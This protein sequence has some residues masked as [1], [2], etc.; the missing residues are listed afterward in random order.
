MTSRLRVAAGLPAI[1]IAVAGCS[2]TVTGATGSTGPTRD[3]SVGATTP[4]GVTT[5][6]EFADADS[7]NPYLIEVDPPD[8][9]VPADG[10]TDLQVT[11]NLGDLVLTVDHGTAPCAAASLVHL[12]GTGFFTGTACHREVD[13]DVVRMLQ[14][15]DPTGTGVGGPTYTSPTEVTG[16]ETYP[17]GTIAMVNSGQGVDGSQFF[18]VW[19][20][21]R[22]PPVYTVVGTV[23]EAG[24]AVLDLVAANGNDGSL[25][26]SPGGGAPTVP[27]TIESV[28]VA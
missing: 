16:E 24:L 19:G 3:P 26:P 5:T 15:G 10:T 22:L 25:D 9:V 11:T 7:T 28:T 23:D 6:C 18:L 17:R 13:N 12:A 2:G 4:T 1:L 8:E 21:S 20:D 14:C 27:V